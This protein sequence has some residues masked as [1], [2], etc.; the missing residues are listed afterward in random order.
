M[1]ELEA[2]S[3]KAIYDWAYAISRTILEKLGR[4]EGVDKIRMIYYAIRGE[5]TPGRFLEK[6]SKEVGE[7]CFSADTSLSVTPKLLQHIHGD[8]F[9]LAKA[10]V[11][12]GLLNALSRGEYQENRSSRGGGMSE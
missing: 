11:I 12:M 5:E 1:S 2:P 8:M 10:A 9:Y 6:L 7:A 4:S 3:L